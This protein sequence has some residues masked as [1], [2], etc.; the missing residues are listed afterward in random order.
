MRTDEE[1][2]CTKF[3]SN[4]EGR[5]AYKETE[6]SPVASETQVVS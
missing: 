1:N 4:I 6:V 5:D 2:W 3:Y